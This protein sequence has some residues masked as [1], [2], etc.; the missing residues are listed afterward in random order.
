MFKDTDGKAYLC[1]VWD[2]AGPNR[3][4][5]IYLMSADYLTLEKRI[6]LFD[7]PSREAPHIFKRNGFYYYG[8]SRTAGIRSTR[9]DL[10]HRDQSCRPLVA[11]EGI[12]N[13]RLG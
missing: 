2:N 10:L 6:Y 1:Y 4:H 13:A 9:H 5:G 7:I 12:V 3:Q 8:T 11:S